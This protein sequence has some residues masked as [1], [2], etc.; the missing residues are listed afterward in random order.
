VSKLQSLFKSTAGGFPKTLTSACRTTRLTTHI[1]R[2]RKTVA[3][4][5]ARTVQ[6]EIREVRAG[7]IFEGKD[8]Y[9]SGGFMSDDKLPEVTVGP[10][11]GK[12]AHLLAALISL[13]LVC[14]IA[15]FALCFWWYGLGLRL[16]GLLATLAP[17][18]FL[19]GI[20]IVIRF[21][22]IGGKSIEG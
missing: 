17:I 16:S 9:R 20:L 14:D 11:I 18:G 13:I 6:S 19:F 12:K 7:L 10:L 15:T 22:P 1:S 5:R 4:W 21:W 8:G 2:N 3:D